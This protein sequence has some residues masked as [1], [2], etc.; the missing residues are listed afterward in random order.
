MH[1]LIILTYKNDFDKEL[2]KS[3][4]LYFNIQLLIY[5]VKITSIRGIFTVKL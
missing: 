3:F 5:C 1:F 4:K 2:S